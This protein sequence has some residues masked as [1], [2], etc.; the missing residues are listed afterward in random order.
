MGKTSLTVKTDSE[1]VKN[2]HEQYMSKWESN[3]YRNSR[4][5]PVANQE[6]FRELSRTIND[7]NMKVK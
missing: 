2:A 3:G 5:K 7:S 6:A 4:N 1:L